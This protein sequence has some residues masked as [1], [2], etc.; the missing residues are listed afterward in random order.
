M[1]TTLGHSKSKYHSGSRD[2]KNSRKKDIL[3]NDGN[4]QKDEKSE[5]GTSD[6]G[7]GKES[8]EHSR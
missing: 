7:E 4:N 5:E 8:G 3:S 6:S 1:K 2:K